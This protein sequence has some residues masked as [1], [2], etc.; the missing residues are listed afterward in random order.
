VV[1]RWIRLV[2]LSRFD[3]FRT[4]HRYLIDYHNH[5]FTLSPAVTSNPGVCGP[6]A[7]TSP[8]SNRTE[9]IGLGYVY[10]H[11]GDVYGETNSPLRREKSWILFSSDTAPHTL[12][13]T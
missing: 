10:L 12:A 1:S 6:L 9:E 4:I 5:S 8:S 11:T 2:S 3:R 13:L 7:L